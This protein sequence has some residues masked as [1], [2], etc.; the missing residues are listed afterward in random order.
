MTQPSI[1]VTI[2]T[3][4]TDVLTLIE[5]L[6]QEDLARA[7][8][9]QREVRRRVLWLGQA[10]CALKPELRE[11]MPEVDWSAWM[12][13]ATRIEQGGAAEHDAIWFAA[14]ALAPTTLGWLRLY[15]GQ[16]PE[17]FAAEA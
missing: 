6:T 5:G 16:R 9:T 4:A 10:A 17:L 2:E 7:R 8:L 14:C 3:A 12:L 1:F 15:R 13:S 11:A